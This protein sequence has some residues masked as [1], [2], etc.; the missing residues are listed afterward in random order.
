MRVLL[1]FSIILISAC[2]ATQQNKTVPKIDHVKYD[3]KYSE[4]VDI[5]KKSA[6]QEQFIELR[7]VYVLTSH[8]K[9]YLSPERALTQTMFQA[10]NNEEWSVCL[11]N[12]NKILEFNYISLSAHYGAMVCSFESDNKTQGK[13]HEYVLNN[14][15]DAI[16][17][18]GDGKTTETAFYCTST[19]E[20]QTFIQLHGL[21]AVDQALIHHKGKSYD[22][23]GVKDPKE[24][25]EF[26]WYFDISAQWALGLKGLR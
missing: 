18:T 23:M 21:E 8:Y 22:L 7:E 13:Y 26:K 20:L 14:L 15:L 11:D 3:A 24:N 12:S 16:W 2:S 6:S 4:L 10:L 9:P 5:V 1:I 25:K 19:P 17:A